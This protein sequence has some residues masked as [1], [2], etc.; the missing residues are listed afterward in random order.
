MHQYNWEEIKAKY[1]DDIEL[2]K[3]LIK[4]KKTINLV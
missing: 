2:I 4:M 3:E 1:P